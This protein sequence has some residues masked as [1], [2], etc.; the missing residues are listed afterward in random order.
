MFKFKKL[1]FGLA[2]APME[3]Q[4]LV[5]LIEQGLAD[6]NVDLASSILMY[7]D[8]VI[9]GAHSFDDLVAKLDLF[10]SEIKALGLR[11]APKKCKI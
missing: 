7:F 5:Q 6:K 4:S 3:F 8:D 9:I 1:P 10:V 2:S 11:L